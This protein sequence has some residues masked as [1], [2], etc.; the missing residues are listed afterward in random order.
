MMKHLLSGLAIAAVALCVTT[1]RADLVGYWSLDGDTDADAG[2]W[3]ASTQ[4]PGGNGE[5]DV[6]F[7][8]DVPTQIGARNAQSIAF[9]SNNDD[10]IVT[11]FDAATAGINGPAVV[12]V[13]FWL[14]HTSAPNNNAVVY[15]GNAS[16]TGGQLVSFEPISNNRLAAYYFNGNQISSNGT[17]LP[18][19]WQ[20]VAWTYQTNHGTSRVFING[21]DVSGSSANPGNTVSFPTDATIT[22]G[23]RVSGNDPSNDFQLADLAIW[24]EILS[25]TRIAE[26]AA[27]ANPA[28]VLIPEPMTMLAVGLS[29][30]GLRGY[31]RKRN[32]PSGRRRG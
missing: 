25:T 32:V 22:L 19:V 29:V 31:V 27:G 4:Q 11:G 24:D 16:A 17:L 18:N 20:H 1:A 5:N 15:L 26:L 3:G 14:K 6:S 12:T 23:D 10:R 8:A 21:V 2:G 7:P 30:A 28:P 9:D 13:A